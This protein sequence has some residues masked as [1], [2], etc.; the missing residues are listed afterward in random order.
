MVKKGCLI[1]IMML[2]NIFFVLKAQ[3]CFDFSI[4][5]TDVN[6]SVFIHQNASTALQEMGITS[7]DTLGIFNNGQCVG[8][9]TVETDFFAFSLWGDD[10]NTEIQ[11]GLTQGESPSHWLIKSTDNKIYHLIPETE[12]NHG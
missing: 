1:S 5:V 7:S 8:V 3:S 11:E 2:Q 6:M 4:N 10:S 12:T 9:K